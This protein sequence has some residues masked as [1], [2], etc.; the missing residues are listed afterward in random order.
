MSSNQNWPVPTLAAPEQ[1]QRV[2]GRNSRIR[3]VY[4]YYNSNPLTTRRFAGGFEVVEFWYSVFRMEKNQVDW[5][6]TEMLGRLSHHKKIKSEE[7][8]LSAGILL[9]RVR[10]FEVIQYNAVYALIHYALLKN[11][12]DLY[13]SL[14]L[15]VR[16]EISLLKFLLAFLVGIVLA[17]PCAI[18]GMFP[19]GF[20]IYEN[21][22]YESGYNS[23]YDA[24]DAAIA[25]FITSSFLGLLVAFI[26]AY[27][28]TL[29]LMALRSAWVYGDIFA[30]ARK[31]VDEN[32]RDDIAALGTDIVSAVM[33]T[34][35]EMGLKQV[36]EASSVPFAV[37]VKTNRA[38][39]NP[40]I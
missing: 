11:E 27:A 1:A 39:R 31:A 38:K 8:S 25:H 24:D 32:Y 9:G 4:D 5:F 34:A 40:R 16:G 3:V 21:T 22:P 18:L 33:E 13:V 10:P 35:D 6:K 37:D 2:I 26:A 30:L 23:G 17:F 29:F 28:L 14:R 36:S 7:V 19:F 12:G 15:L 20:L